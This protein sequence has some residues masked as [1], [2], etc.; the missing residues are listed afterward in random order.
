M[1]RNNYNLPAHP[2]LREGV[3]KHLGVRR[4]GRASSVPAGTTFIVSNF[5]TWTATVTG[6]VANEDGSDGSYIRMPTSAGSGDASEV[7]TA[8]KATRFAWSPDLTIKVSVGTVIT[9]YRAWIGMFASTPT[10]LATI[11]GISGAAFGYDTGV[12]GTVFWRCRS[13]DAS[14]QKTTAT[15]V[16]VVVSAKVKFR[17][18]C[19]ATNSLVDFYIN[20][21]LVATHSASIP[22]AATPLDVSVSVTTLEAVAKRISV[23]YANLLQN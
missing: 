19:D 10:A 22:V 14:T 2:Q 9:N 7:A 13:S 20:D 8:T 21:D 6:A 3:E 18:V 4:L 12:D 11:A 5:P 1:T 15:T 23:G 16:P 17:I